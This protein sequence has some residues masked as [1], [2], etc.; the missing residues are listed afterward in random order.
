MLL[1][2]MYVITATERKLE[3]ALTG[4]NYEEAK[5]VKQ[6]APGLCLCLPSRGTQ[7]VLPQLGFL[8][9]HSGLS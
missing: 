4:L 8:N 9:M 3:P 2:I 5:L 6:Q 7:Q 1:V